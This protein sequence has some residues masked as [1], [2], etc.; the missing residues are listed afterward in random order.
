M[1]ELLLWYYCW[2]NSISNVSVY[3]KYMGNRYFLRPEF[4]G[5]LASASTPSDV[6]FLYLHRVVTPSPSCG[7]EQ[8]TS[9]PSR[10]C[11]RLVPK[12]SERSKNGNVLPAHNWIRSQPAT[13]SPLTM[14]FYD[15]PT[16]PPGILHD[17]LVV[18]QHSG[19]FG[20]HGTASMAK[21]SNY[22]SLIAGNRRVASITQAGEC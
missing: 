17:F 22:S 1:T 2:T 15:S 14:F 16:P 9:T 19:D 6:F 12:H 11:I 8:C 5:V 7:P 18:S 20:T 3:Q 10:R 21:A 13:V 4:S